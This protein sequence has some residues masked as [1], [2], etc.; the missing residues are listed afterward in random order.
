MRLSKSKMRRHKEQGFS[1][2]EM[3]IAMVILAVGLGAL[4]ILFVTAMNT[5]LK[6]SRDTGA[7]LLAEVSDLIV[8][9]EDTS[10]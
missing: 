9:G 8:A 5:N 7:T 1:I 6:S 10:D 2:I 4:T 3:M